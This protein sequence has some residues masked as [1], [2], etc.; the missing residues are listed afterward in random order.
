MLE[1]FAQIGKRQLGKKRVHFLA[2]RRPAAKLFEPDVERNVGFDRAKLR[3]KNTA[4]LPSARASRIRA[5]LRKF[6]LPISSK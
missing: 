4:A 2:F 1:D 6:I 3:L 5:A